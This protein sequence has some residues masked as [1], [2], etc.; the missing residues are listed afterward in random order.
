MLNWNEKK[1][2]IGAH[3]VKWWMF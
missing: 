3:F 1:M 2:L